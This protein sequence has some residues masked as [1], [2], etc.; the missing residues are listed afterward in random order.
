[1]IDTHTHL[2]STEFDAD[3]HGDRAVR[4]ALDAGVSHLVLPNCDVQTVRPMLDL[5]SRWL[6]VTSVAMGLHPTEVGDSWREDLQTL[7]CEL[8]TGR[9]VAV[10]EVGIDLYWDKSRE[11]EQCEVF[12]RQIEWAKAR[13]LP[14]IIHCREGLE[15]TLECIRGCH[16]GEHPMVFH[17]FTGSVDDV[18]R[19]RGTVPQAMFGVNGV[20]TFKSASALREAL[21]E[22]GEGHL[23]LETDSPYL[24]PVPMRGRRNESALLPHVLAAAASSMAMRPEQ[25]EAAT[26]R[27]ARELFGLP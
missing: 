14:L 25:L 20:V 24:A 5:H 8:D 6:E 11:L 21:P 7:E 1:M 4:D 19:I 12:C 10:G 18:R 16:A 15:Q 9:Y 3:G 17:S 27:N 22:I 26:D 13:N 23:V 2:Y